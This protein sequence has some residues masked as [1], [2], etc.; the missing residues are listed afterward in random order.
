MRIGEGRHHRDNLRDPIALGVAERCHLFIELAD[1]IRGDGLSADVDDVA[2]AKQGQE[3][4]RQT[5][6]RKSR[7]VARQQRETDKKADGRQLETVD[8]KIPAGLQKVAPPSTPWICGLPDTLFI[9]CEPSLV[10]QP[11]PIIERQPALHDSRH[12]R[13]DG[14][15]RTNS[16]EQ[17]NV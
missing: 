16:E 1:R 7:E 8:V 9:G 13:A 6:R 5:E 4:R 10:A 15:A 2:Q 11:C 17:E 14:A 3:I 12:L